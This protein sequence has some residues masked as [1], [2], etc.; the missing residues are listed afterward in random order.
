MRAEWQ[1][2]NYFTYR[3]L[4]SGIDCTCTRFAEWHAYFGC[5]WM[6]NQQ[7]NLE[8]SSRCLELNVCCLPNHNPTTLQKSEC[9]DFGTGWKCTPAQRTW[10]THHNPC[11]IGLQSRTWLKPVIYHAY[12]S[13][14]RRK[15]R[16]RH[17]THVEPRLNE[18]C[19]ER[20][21]FRR[22]QGYS[23]TRVQTQV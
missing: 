4:L 6:K 2:S 19:A 21:Y 7:R 13:I 22:Y 10:T 8:M 20:H 5:T 15:K 23:S 18:C 9:P 12:N 16:P 11:E 14:S 1:T 17:W 3:H